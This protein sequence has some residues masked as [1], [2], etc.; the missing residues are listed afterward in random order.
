MPGIRVAVAGFGTVVQ[1][2]RPEQLRLHHL[3]AHSA[4]NARGIVKDQVPRCGPDVLEHPAQPVANA[5]G[6]LARYACTKRMFENGNVTTRMCRIC[7]IPAMMASACPKST[8]TVPAGQTSSVNPSPAVLMRAVHFFAWR[9]TGEYVPVKPCSS[10]SR[11][12]IRLAVCRCL[13]GRRWSSVSHVS[14]RCSNPVSTEPPG[15]ATG[16]GGAGEKSSCSAYLATESRLTPN[17][18]AISRPG[19]PVSPNA[20]DIFLNGHGYRHLLSSPSGA[21]ALSMAAP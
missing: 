18:R 13:R 9:W 5:L 7:R 8:C 17:L 1:L 16:A 11:S 3:R 10:T 2:E 14:M 21:H 15:R 4:S 19:L 6:G 20:S 12:K